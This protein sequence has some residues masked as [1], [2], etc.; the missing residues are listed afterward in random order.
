MATIDATTGLSSIADG[1]VAVRAGRGASTT[2]GEIGGGGPAPTPVIYLNRGWCSDHS[3]PEPWTS[4]GAPSATRLGH[5]ILVGS[6]SHVVL[7]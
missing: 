2:G 3:A 4:S 6:T 1:G 5:D 7:P